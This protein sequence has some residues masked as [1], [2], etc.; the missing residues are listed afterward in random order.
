MTSRVCICEVI[1]EKKINYSNLNGDA[2]PIFVWSYDKLLLG[3]FPLKALLYDGSVLLWVGMNLPLAETGGLLLT[4]I[5]WT[6]RSR[7]QVI[8]HLFLRPESPINQTG[9]STQTFM[10]S[11]E[12]QSHDAII[13]LAV[14][15]FIMVFG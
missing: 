15:K 14:K 11:M 12:T 2:S 13:F 1:H 9:D 5:C 6:N 10:H 8:P 7:R 3:V 4:M